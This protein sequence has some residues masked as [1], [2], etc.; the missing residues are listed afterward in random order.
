MQKYLTLF[1]LFFFPNL[2]HADEIPLSLSIG[3]VSS[4][5]SKLQFSTTKGSL[6]GDGILICMVEKYACTVYQTSDFSKVIANDSVEDVATGKSI[7]SYSFH[8]SKGQYLERGV[9]V[10]FIFPKGSIKAS[11][12]DFDREGGVIIKKRATK[13]IISYCLSSEGVHV[14]S[15][16][17]NIHLYYSLGYDVEANC[18][19]EVYK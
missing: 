17:D 14:I 12:V 18:S 7:Y 16:F 13:D 6:L 2:S 10:V 5:N 4:L 15:R 19:D 1:F 11:D 3:V 9:G 8:G